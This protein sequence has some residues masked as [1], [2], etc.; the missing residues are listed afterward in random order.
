MGKAPDTTSHKPETQSVSDLRD[1]KDGVYDAV[2]GDGL[3]RG[4]QP[5]TDPSQPN[6]PE[7]L[8]RERKGPLDKD[9]GRH[10]EISK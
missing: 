2:N 6:L 3:P 4:D 10:E 8:R 1:V 7:G 9:S 5:E